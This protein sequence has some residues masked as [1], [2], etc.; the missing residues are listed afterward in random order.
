MMD[1][2][3]NMLKYATQLQWVKKVNALNYNYN[4]NTPGLQCVGLYLNTLHTPTQHAQFYL[5]ILPSAI[6]I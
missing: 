4:R 3:L 6:Q 2:H 5:Y 1:D